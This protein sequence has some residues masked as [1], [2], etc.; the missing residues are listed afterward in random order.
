ME[1]HDDNRISS[2]AKFQVCTG[3]GKG[4]TLASVSRLVQIGHWVVLQS[5]ELG[6]Y[7][8]NGVDGYRM[9][10]PGERRLL[11]GLVCQ[12]RS[13]EGVGTAG[14]SIGFTRPGW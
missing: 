13:M 4:K 3:L 5:P 12:G 10:A 6:S 8:E 2:W 7:V 1:V 14:R 9:H 11:R